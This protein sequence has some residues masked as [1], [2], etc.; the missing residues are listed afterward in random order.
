[1]AIDLQ[2]APRAADRPRV[3]AAT[4]GPPD[5]ALLAEA[6]ALL[7]AAHR[8]LVWVGGGGIS[9]RPELADLLERRTPDSH[10]QLRSRLVPESHQRV[11]GNYATAPGGRALLADADV[12]LTIGTHFRS[13]ETA[14]DSLNCRVHIQLTST[15]TLRA[16]STRLLSPCRRRG[17]VLTALLDASQQRYGDGLAGPRGPVDA[18]SALRHAIGPQAAVCDAIREA[19]PPASSWPATSPSRPAAGE[20]GCWRSPTRRPTSSLAAAA[21]DRASPWA[22]AP[23]SAAPNATVV[24]AGDG[25]LA[26][27]LGELLTLAQERPRSPCRLQRRRLRRPAQ[28]AGPLLRAPLR[29]RPG[30][31]RLRPARPRLRIAVPPDRY[32]SDAGPVIAEAVASSGPTLVEIDLA[33]LGPM[34]VPFTPPV[35]I[36]SPATGQGGDPR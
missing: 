18:R 32:R 34:N 30:H 6:A 25:G 11:L 17:R 4:P 13:N 27:H 19:L 26:V 20:T 16:G 35:K 8:P 7:A 21:S 22:S 15:R 10:L 28:H 9:A 14:D 5:P 1:M 2:F 12:L 29:S 36:P 23:R 33:A 24:I 31:P 3:P